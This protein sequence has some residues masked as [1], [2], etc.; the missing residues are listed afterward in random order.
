MSV[1]TTITDFCEILNPSELDQ[2][3]R[4]RLL[5][6]FAAAGGSISLG[7]ARRRAESI[8]GAGASRTHFELRIMRDYG[9]LEITTDESSHWRSIS[10]TPLSLNKI[11][12]EFTAKQH[13]FSI[14]GCFVRSKIKNLIKEALNSGV[15]IRISRSGFSL[16]PPSLYLVSNSLK[17]I[18]T[19]AGAFGLSLP[20]TTAC[21]EI[22]EWAADLDEWLDS[23]K[24]RLR[25][26]SGITPHQSEFCPSMFTF[27]EDGFVGTLRIQCIEDPLVT[28]HKIFRI[29]YKSELQGIHGHCLAT[30]A[31]WAKWWCQNLE[32]GGHWKSNCKLSEEEMDLTPVFYESESGSLYF[33]RELVLPRVLRR[34]IS[35]ASSLPPELVYNHENPYYEISGDF[36]AYATRRGGYAWKYSLIPE[37]LCRQVL[38]KVCATPISRNIVI[39]EIEHETEN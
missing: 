33:Q 6:S 29:V 35:L 24:S 9:Y 27:N 34:A 30:D 1:Q 39:T 14:T 17:A 20:I 36:R 25:D 4:F 16:L 26:G 12:A 21:A 28:G 10:P 31:S 37:N 2:D 18:E 23:T 7:E 15:E 5:E 3:P 32:C 13:V 22:A 19:L 38:S 11:P 8:V